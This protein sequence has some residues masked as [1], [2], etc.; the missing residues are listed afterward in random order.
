M[1]F[2][3]NDD[4]QLSEIATPSHEYNFVHAI[5]SYLEILRALVFIFSERFEVQ[6]F[7]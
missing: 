1:G 4:V 7:N 5:S 2:F 6:N 3:L